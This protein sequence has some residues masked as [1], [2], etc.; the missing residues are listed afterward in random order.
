MA[1]TR[2][3]QCLIG[4]Q[5]MWERILQALRQWSILIVGVVLLAAAL[6]F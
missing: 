1:F 2:A 5:A 4:G 6:A 3:T